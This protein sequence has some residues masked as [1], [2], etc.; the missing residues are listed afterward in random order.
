M[1]VHT[2]GIDESLGTEDRWYCS[3]YCEG[4]TTHTFIDGDNII[5]FENVNFKAQ[6]SLP[7]D[8]L[9][10]HQEQTDSMSTIK[11]TFNYNNLTNNLTYV[12]SSGVVPNNVFTNDY[13][14]W[15]CRLYIGNNSENLNGSWNNYNMNNNPI[16][17][18]YSQANG[19]DSTGTFDIPTQE[20]TI[21]IY[22]PN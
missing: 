6:F 21:E 12:T 5:A 1:T 19:V 10:K 14:I 8:P 9:Y 4:Q 20:I 22:Q 3:A 2:S 17:M 7:G 13:S 16:I 15:T 11:Y 18:N